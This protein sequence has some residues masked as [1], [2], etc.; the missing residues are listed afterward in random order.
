MSVINDMLR[1]LEVRRAGE[2][3]DQ[4]LQREIRALPAQRR[5]SPW[6]WGLPLLVLLGGGAIALVWWQ[7]FPGGRPVGTMAAAP[8]PA[9]SP[10]PVVMP[11]PAA[12]PPSLP[13]PAPLAAVDALR[14]AHLL[15]NPPAEPAVAAPPP[16]APP[17]RSARDAVPSAAPPVRPEAAPPR[18]KA[19]EVPPVAPGS[20][21]K[22]AVQGSA[23][24]RAEAEFRRAQSLLAAG[25]NSAAYDALQ[26]ALRHDP[27]HVGPRQAL[28]RLLLEGRRIDEAMTALQEGLDLHPA[29]IGWAMS[30]A[31]LLV[32]RNDLAG[33]EKV[34]VRSQHLALG[35][36][37]YAGFHGHV[38]NRLGRYRDAAERYGAASRLAPAEGRWW[39]GLG[40]ALDGEGKA[41][42]ARE[43]Y[44]RALA[45]GNL[46][47]DLAALAEARLH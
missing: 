46:N 7:A 28:L 32:E 43:A 15:E 25:Q 14:S 12:A 4:Q 23:R 40:Q 10:P 13:D 20:I 2:L 29:Q 41:G 47:A 30:L 3:G 38:L 37:E 16:S 6:R 21:E 36:A 24:E 19:A 44:R 39:F 35:N 34:L 5:P 45:S 18:P 11:A 17:A 9:V 27:A 1:D 33:A 8:A 26:A 42:E 22:T 31:R